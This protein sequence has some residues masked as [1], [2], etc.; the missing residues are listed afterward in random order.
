MNFFF[1]QLILIRKK[2]PVSGHSKW[3]DTYRKTCILL[4]NPPHLS[5]GVWPPDWPDPHELPFEIRTLF[6]LILRKP[7]YQATPSGQIPT[8]K[9]ASF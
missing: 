8:E 1:L 6:G 4:K 7:R 2:P 5:I 9:L 3:P